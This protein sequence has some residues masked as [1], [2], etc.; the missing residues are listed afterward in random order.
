MKRAISLI[1][2]AA[3]AVA[4]SG[5][6][7]AQAPGASAAA[8]KSLPTVGYYRVT[9]QNLTRGQPFSPG[10]IVTH[11]SNAVVWRLA[12]Q[13]SEGIAAIAEDGNADIETADLQ[14]A[15]GIHDVVETSGPINRLGGTAPPESFAQYTVRALPGDRLSIAVMMICTNDGFTGVDS[16]RLPQRD[17]QKVIYLASA[18]DAGV[19]QNTE[20]SA[21]V[22]DGCGALGPVPLPMDGNNDALPADGNLIFPHPGIVGGRDL[23][24]DHSVADHAWSNPVARITVRKLPV[25]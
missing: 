18:Y 12:S 16:V 19:E 25:P 22:P 20:N 21:D 5:V 13:P 2:P 10:V 9:I 8:A 15:P 23:T 7:Y 3:F 4:A 1:V 24:V 11:T 6:A 17:G 14:G